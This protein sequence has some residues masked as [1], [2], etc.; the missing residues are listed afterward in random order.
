MQLFTFWPTV[1]RQFDIWQTRVVSLK[2]G[3]MVECLLSIE[4]KL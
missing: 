3:L 4:I 2:F 1:I